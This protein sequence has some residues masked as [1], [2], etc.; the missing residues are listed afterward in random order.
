MVGAP[1]RP[2]EPPTTTTTPESNFEPLRGL[3]G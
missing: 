2:I 3:R 1:V